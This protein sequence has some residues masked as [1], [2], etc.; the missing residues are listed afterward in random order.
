MEE[1][2]HLLRRLCERVEMLEARVSQLE[3]GRVVLDERVVAAKEGELGGKAYTSLPGGGL[4][5]ETKIPFCD[6]CGRKAGEFNICIGCGRK[7]CVECSVAYQS[8]VYCA[9]CLS[10]ALP[11]TKEEYKVLVAI[12]NS[13]TDLGKIAEASNLEVSRV[14]ACVRGL[15]DKSLVSVKGLLLFRELS[16]LDKGLEAI[17]AYRQVY[18]GDE[19]VELFDS[20][21]RRV[22]NEE[23]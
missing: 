4:I 22:L 13:L 9:N 16:I 19:D 7:L 2:A 14:R 10:E 11:L 12:A 3:S 15:A 8:K 1:V 17:A 23:G 21:L 18:G 5:K 20:A 6:I